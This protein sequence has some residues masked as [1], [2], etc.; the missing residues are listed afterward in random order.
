[1]CVVC[2]VLNGACLVDWVGLT[3]E[4]CRQHAGLRGLLAQPTPL[5]LRSTLWKGLELSP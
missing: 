5:S 3:Q 1:M 2:V 4:L